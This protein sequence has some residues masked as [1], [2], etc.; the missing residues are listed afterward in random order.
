MSESLLKKVVLTGI[1][2]ASLV[3]FSGCGGRLSFV[4]SEGLREAVKYNIEQEKER[5]GKQ[6]H[7]DACYPLKFVVYEF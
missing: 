2:L 5:I 3:S 6:S 4:G 1:T 7:E